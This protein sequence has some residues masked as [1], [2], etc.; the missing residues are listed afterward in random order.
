MIK[1]KDTTLICVDGI[2]KSDKAIKSIEAST[3]N[4]KYEEVILITPDTNIKDNTVFKVRNINKMSWEEY[5]EFI[6]NNLTDYFNTNYVLLSQDDGFVSNHNKWTNDFFNY[7]YIGAPWPLHLVQHLLFNLS[8][9]TDFHGSK[10]QTNIPK[11]KDY[12]IH[13]Y[14][15]GNG[16]FSFRSKNLC[17]FTKNY[18]NKYPG[19]PEDCIISIYEKNNL[20]ENGLT[21]APV[22]LASQFSVENPNEYNPYRD[23]TQSFGFHRFNY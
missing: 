10:F 3:E 15:V 9:E 17:N 7:D 22:K 2:G 20:L 14:R 11:I 8:N 21:I 6:L 19:K 1:I 4:I 5:N 23:I 16:G 13:N 18:T 12:N